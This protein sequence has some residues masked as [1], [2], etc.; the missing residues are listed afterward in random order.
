MLYLDIPSPSDLARLNAMRS[1]ICVSIYLPTSPLGQEAEQSRIELKNLVREALRQIEESAGDKRRAA[2]LAEQLD[3]LVED[4]EFWRFQATSLAILATPDTLQTLRV[5]NTFA[6]SVA[7][8][9]RFHLAPLMRTAAFAASALVLA[10]SENDVRAISVPDQGPA[11]AV[12]VA[13]LPKD[14]ASAAGKSTIND[15]SPSRRIHGSEGQKV[16][17]RQYA[18]KVHD[19]MRSFLAG[20][21]VPLILAASQPLAG[22]YRS[23]NTHPHLA[24]DGIDGSPDG[25]TPAQLAEKARPVLD[26]LQRVRLDAWRAEFDAKAAQGRT[27]TDLAAAAR[28]ATAGAVA[29]MLVDIDGETPGHVDENGTVDFAAKAGAGSYDIGDEIAGRALASGATVIGV[30]RADIPGGAPLAA[31]LRYPL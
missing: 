2:A 1:D 9:D 24:A 26:A 5:P 15:R 7:V 12:H 10:L 21:D 27:T 8:S 28:A 23:L 29:S 17:L 25:L 30:R 20:R 22:I 6:P 4:D 19:A 13:G 11:E 3:D 14:A 18:R 16:R 31:I